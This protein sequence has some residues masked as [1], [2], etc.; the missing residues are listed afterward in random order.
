MP[1][2]R[3]AVIA[4]SSVSIG[5]CSAA[6]V[7]SQADVA[8]SPIAAPP[9]A[10]PASDGEQRA[11]GGTGRPMR[12]IERIALTPRPPGAA[13]Q[14]DLAPSGRASA[15]APPGRWATRRT[16]APP[17]RRITH[18][19]QHDRLGDLVEARRRLVEEQDRGTADERPGE[20]DPPALAARQPASPLAEDPVRRQ[21]A[22]PDA[23]EGRSDL[24][25]GRGGRRQ[26]HVLGHG[27]REQVRDLRH[28]CHPR[29]PGVGV[30]VAHVGLGPVGGPHDHPPRRRLQ[31]PQD[32]RQ[33]RALAGARWTRDGHDLTRPH[34]QR[35][36]GGRDEVPAW[37]VHG[38]PVDHHGPDG[39]RRS[40]RHRR[41]PAPAHR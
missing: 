40:A 34:H 2:A 14:R 21:V 27:A 15:D 35:D 28:P 38:H 29:P 1:N 36:T 25:V 24:L 32:H 33:Q 10:T 12:R 16:A 5:G 26:P 39:L 8:A 18:R 31:Q 13:A 4:A 20:A 23:R 6:R 37:L 11:A 17:S 19:G 22:Q 7:I 30:E 9:A 41:H 3:T